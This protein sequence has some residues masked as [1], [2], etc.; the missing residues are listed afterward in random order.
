MKKTNSKFFMVFLFLSFLMVNKGFAQTTYTVGASGQDFVTIQQAIDNASVM[1]GDIISIVDAVHTEAG[2]IVNKNLT[3]IGQGADLTIVQAAE[4][5]DMAYDRVFNISA[6]AS[7]VIEDL[8]VTH[9]KGSSY[10]GGI[11]NDG[12]LLVNRCVITDNKVNTSSENLEGGGG[13]FNSGILSIKF[14]E[15][16]NNYSGW[17]GGGIWMEDDDEESELYIE[18]CIIKDNESNRSGAGLGS[19]YGAL[20]DIK[21]TLVVN[22]NAGYKAGGIHLGDS[23]Y[24]DIILNSVTISGNS[25]TYYTAGIHNNDG[26]LYMQNS[27]VAGNIFTDA[28]EYTDIYNDD[29]FI[30]LGNNIIGI[31]DYDQL[32]ALESDQV[33]TVDDSFDP[34]LDENY[35]PLLTS[36][37][38][39]YGPKNFTSLDLEDV[40]VYGNPRIFDGEVDVIDIGAVE[41]QAEPLPTYL[42]SVEPTTF[43]FGDIPV[44]TTAYKSIVIENYG[45]ASL[46]LDSV[47]ASGGFEIF[48]QSKSAID[49]VLYNETVPAH[50]TKRIFVSILHDTDSLFNGNLVIYSN[51]ENNPEITI[52]LSA[53]IVSGLDYFKGEIIANTTWCQDTLHIGGDVTVNNDVTLTICA[54]TV[55]DFLGD[56]SL[57]VNG[58][59]HVNGNETDTV[60][61]TSNSGNWSGIRFENIMNS[62]QNDSYLSYTRVENSSADNGDEYSKGGGIYLDYTARVS[63]L[64]SEITDNTAVENGGG[65]YNAGELDI[66]NSLISNNSTISGSND[67]G[68]GGIA[69]A[70]HLNILNSAIHDNYSAF[71]GGGILNCDDN[72]VLYLE[73]DS[74][75]DNTASKA[76][77]GIAN[78]GAEQV[79]IINCLI[80]NNTAQSNKAGGI[81]SGG[82]AN[83]VFNIISSTIYGNIASSEGGGISNRIA[84]F[85]LINSIVAGN[86]A[87][88]YEDVYNT[89]TLNSGG[90]NLIG[91]EDGT[92]FPAVEGDLVGTNTSPIPAML[93]NDYSL[94]DSSIAIN[95]GIPDTTGLYIPTTDLAGNS[96]IYDGDLDII[97]IGAFELQSNPAVNYNL[98]ISQNN[99]DFVIASVDSSSYQEVE[100]SNMGFGI[101]EI[102]S[103]I[104]P[105]GYEIS[106]SGSEY[107]DTL[108]DIAILAYNSAVL[109]IKFTPTSAIT[110]AGNIMVKSNDTG[111]PEQNISVTGDGT[112]YYI[113][114]AIINDYVNICADTVRVMSDVTI[115]NGATL[116]IC[117]GTV[118]EFR[119]DYRIE[120]QGQILAEGTEADT[121]K[122]TNINGTGDW[123]GIRFANSPLSNDS[124]KFSYTIFEHG[125]AYNNYGGALNISYFSKISLSHCIFENNHASSNGGAI[126]LYNASLNIN[127]CIFDNNSVSSRGGAICLEGDD[128][129]FELKITNSIL[130]NNT[131][132][133]HGGAICKRYSNAALTIINSKLIDNT[134]GSYGGAIYH[135]YGKEFTMENS[136][137]A[138]NN[139]SYGGGLY[140]RTYSDVKISNS[141]I[142][143]N[144]STSFAGGLYIRYCD[145]YVNNTIIADNNGSGSYPD[146]YYDGDGRNLISEGYNI[147]GNLGS[148]YDWEAGTGDIL[149]YTGNKIE[150]YLEADYTPTDSSV[151]V[152]SGNPVGTY[153]D[154]DLAGNPRIFDGTVDIID[155]GAYELQ[156][157][158]VLQNMVLAVDKSA[159]DFAYQQI[160]EYSYREPFTISHISGNNNLIISS[161]T[162]PTGYM[163]TIDEGE[164]YVSS[165]TDVIVGILKKLTVEVVMNPLAE[166][167]YSGNITINSNATESVTEIPIT[168]F[169]A[170]MSPSFLFTN[171]APVIDGTVDDLWNI[172]TSDRLDVKVEDVSDHDVDAKFRSVWDNDSLYLLVTIQ[173]DTLYSGDVDSTINDNIVLYL[174]FNNSKGSSY[175]ADDY[176]IRF[177]WD[178][179][180]YTIETGSAIS[181][182]HFEETTATDS[183]SYVF[184]IA[185]PWASATSITPVSGTEIGIDMNV[186]DN[187]GFGLEDEMAWHSDADDKDTNPSA[188]GTAILL[189]E[190]GADPLAPVME[191]SYGETDFNITCED[192]IVFPLTINNTGIGRDLIIG[193]ELKNLEDILSLLNDNYINI[194]DLI[195]NKFDFAYDGGSNYIDDGGNDMYD[196]ANYLNTNYES[197]IDYSDNVV[198]NDVAAFGDNS[199]YFTRHFDGLFVMVADVNNIDYF[200]LTGDNGADGSGNVEG[201]I[202]DVS[203]GGVDYQGFV[204]RIYNSGDPSINHLII[205]EKAV[206]ADHN[207]SYDTNDDQHEVTGLNSAKRI[208]YLLFA[209]SGA[210]ID[211]EATTQIMK[212][213]LNIA[214]KSTLSGTVVPA[215]E[216]IVAN[217]VYNTS[218][219]SM[220]YKEEDII[221]TSNDPVNSS[222]TI[223]ITITKNGIPEIELLQSEF[224][225]DEV[226]ANH[227]AKESLFITNNGCIPLTVDSITSTHE[228]F[229]V[230]NDK[231][232]IEPSDTAEV[233]IYFLPTEMGEFNE[234]MTI[235]NNGLDKVI[236]V[237]GVTADTIPPVIVSAYVNDDRPD[238][239]VVNFNE[240]IQASGFDGFTLNGGIGTIFGINDVFE[241]TIEFTLSADIIFGEILTFDYDSLSGNVQDIATLE[242]PMQSITDIF[243]ANNVEFID[244]VTPTLV[245]ISVEN[246]NPSQLILEFNED[247]LVTNQSG[248][249][250][251]GTTGSITGIS[252]SGTDVLLITLDAN[253][254]YGEVLTIDYVAVVGNITDDAVTPNALEDISGLTIYNY[255]DYVDVF[256]PNYISAKVEDAAPTQVVVTFDEPVNTTDETGFTLTGTT[257]TIT[258]VTGSGTEIL[259]FTLDADI[260]FGENLMLSYSI[261]T[262]DVTDA[263]DVPNNLATFGPVTVVNNVLYS[264]GPQ[265][266]PTVI[267][268]SVEDATPNEVV[269]VFDEIVSLTNQTGFSVS[270]ITASI[271]GVTGTGTAILTFTLDVSVMYGDI[272]LLSYDATGDVQDVELNSLAAFLNYNVV[273]NVAYVD[274]VAPT[275]T[276]AI[277]EDATPT[278]MEL[279]FDEN[280]AFTDATGFTIN[281]TTGLVVSA[282]GSGTNIMSLELDAAVAYGEAITIDYDQPTGNVTDEAAITNDLAT[283]AGFVVANYVEFVDTIKPQVVS[284]SVEDAN[285]FDVVIGF[286]EE[287]SYTDFTGITVNGTA[288]SIIG[289]AGDNTKTIILTLDK[290]VIY[291]ELLTMDYSGGNITDLSNVPNSL[292]DFTDVAIV[293]NIVGE[294]RSPYFTYA[295]V[296]DASRSVIEVT[297]TEIVVF[298]DYTGFTV[299]GTASLITGLAG[300]GTNTLT[301]SLDADAVYEDNNIVL[302][303]DGYGN[304]TDRIG[305]ILMPVDFDVVNNIIPRTDAT[306]SDLTFNATTVTGFDPVT[307]S[308]A[309]ELAHET[310]IVPTVDATT[311][312]ASATIAVVDAT[313]LPGSTIVTVTAQDGVTEKVYTINF[314]IA[315]DSNATLSDLTIDA[316]TVAGFNAATTTYEVELAYGTTVIPTVAAT[317]TDANAIFAI[318]D[319]TELPGST[320]VTVTAE[321]GVTEIVY[322]IIFTIAPDSD[323]TLSDLTIDAA[324]VEGFDAA[325]TTYDV[326]LTYGT[327]VIP[328]VVATA[329]DTN[330]T[331]V[332]VDATELPGST[333]VTVTA[334]DGVTE[335]VY[336]INFTVATGIFNISQKDINIYPNPS[337]GIFNVELEGTSS[338]NVNIEILSLDGKVLYNKVFINSDNID[339]D[340]STIQKGLYFIKLTVNEEIIIQRI[341]IE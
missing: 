53:N 160:N 150:V 278:I 87:S 248:I 188:F 201:A 253:V 138:G 209:S 120:V 99:F 91:N 101:V 261:T 124:S 47:F 57:K 46:T 154:L 184:E 310:I 217:V 326:K 256:A 23:F 130:S 171:T 86:T 284:A 282:S 74:I 283:F 118:V 152:N 73:R 136:L 119:G 291:G 192:S 108:I 275:L 43:N 298:T 35:S 135:Y 225:F 141:S 314:T 313:E 62:I 69:N 236:N 2:I 207:Y 66:L 213:F 89:G 39:N 263:A 116:D 176:M 132:S 183:N 212:K 276:M 319:A 114:P 239:L 251:N 95:H 159:I 149:G 246:A 318:V 165:L 94:T 3:I 308:Y 306:L 170:N 268:L 151:A 104:A 203:V 259:T 93:E 206:G 157:E 143:N 164:T 40:D 15:I 98:Q 233:F 232:I 215:G 247:V 29:T 240:E 166:Q 6:G 273:N 13:L 194:T 292:D 90:Y 10:G 142:I 202:L 312:D 123:G 8:T 337:N 297:C 336:T 270:G 205:V 328:T 221:I 78:T 9:G 140:I 294:L 77:G 121:I 187:D 311:A 161:I 329:N 219:Y 5:T 17:H 204:K 214:G 133:S 67:M 241:S 21:N 59:I 197:E 193:G 242:N 113:I 229:F 146:I 191:I 75:T 305:N 254:L 293:N 295:V 127:D 185:I 243:V 265:T 285:P 334:E 1:D 85:N 76:G 37:C 262:G 224:D 327:T 33:G 317:T 322:T 237:K 30:S 25:G 266:N 28:D 110:F 315:P 182:L 330:A 198:L 250:I 131:S 279:T 274:N 260:I 82:G 228:Y 42:I 255:V 72:A 18:N 309:V 196:D 49:T 324:T 174:D 144:S 272:V 63:I 20:I 249:S 58:A 300:S 105:E 302:S 112:G 126:Y 333:V 50:S 290:D 139:G 190:N 267:G 177:N 162:V 296:E 277:V 156:S 208:Y 79:D 257:G 147:V 34:E 115:E 341:I 128:N 338:D 179:D 303:Y 223:S 48:T 167:E 339:I 12:E 24:G 245:K 68:G 316:T 178:Y 27:I 106:V 55:I 321:D 19:S 100:L 340:V 80:A 169:G 222:D 189:N 200:E 129:I 211:D 60:F 226:R 148:E 102:D 234:F 264:G 175:D 81:H 145:F 230:Q 163:L 56:Y 244:D 26:I 307:I 31:D 7:V 238:I 153:P 258:G 103:I 186:I 70:G 287:V 14:S 92:S 269:V 88:S 331:V 36:P 288:G 84:T 304:V 54:G 45:Q 235:Y 109:T 199:S 41:L 155:I 117:P 83:G 125:E 281:G 137:V 22:N 271:T 299:S 16:S 286:S 227:Y 44:D 52:S 220:T 38:I 11:L 320:V 216:S 61:F 180:Q 122:F 173:D 168:G 96:R 107:N 158:K 51:A 65:I 325:I 172:I 64:N 210:L 252:G 134:A 280:I 289:I 335:M 195:P 4:S 301:F 332:I 32:G 323:A 71:H 218:S 111:E 181:G 231:F 97:D